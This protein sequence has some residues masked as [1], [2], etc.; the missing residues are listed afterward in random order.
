MMMTMILMFTLH[1]IRMTDQVLT[2]KARFKL[3]T[4]TYIQHKKNPEA[5][6][7]RGVDFF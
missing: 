1:I 5:T 7:L 6:T 4:A 3:T 2:I